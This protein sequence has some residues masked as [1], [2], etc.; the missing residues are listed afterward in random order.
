MERYVTE[1]TLNDVQLRGDEIIFQSGS[2][3]INDTMEYGKTGITAETNSVG[4]AWI[5][6]LDGHHTRTDIRLFNYALSDGRVLATV[7][8][9]APGKSGW[10]VLMYC[11]DG[12]TL[13]ALR[14]GDGGLEPLVADIGDV[15]VEGDM[16][17][18]AWSADAAALAPNSGIP[19]GTT[20]YTISD[21]E[22]S[23]IEVD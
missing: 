11:Y 16:I 15:R 2:L 10:I 8:L 3:R 21:S 4:S 17:Y 13:K 6:G 12:E 22:N 23:L 9:P 7:W 1:L 19:T 18:V 5:A 14:N 20:A